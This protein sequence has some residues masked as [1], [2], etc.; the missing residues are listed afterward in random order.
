MAKSIN[1]KTANKFLL[2]SI[3]RAS[4]KNKEEVF[5]KKFKIYRSRMQTNADNFFKTKNQADDFMYTVDTIEKKIKKWLKDDRFD[6][7]ELQRQMNGLIKSSREYQKQVAVIDK[8]REMI[9]Q[10]PDNSRWAYV[11]TH[12]VKTGNHSDE[13]A[14]DLANQPTEGYTKQEMDAILETKPNHKYCTC[15]GRRMRN[16][17]I[18]VQSDNF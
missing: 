14:R 7:K 2:N 13:C 12:A 4:D 6:Q 16:V 15:H 1:F 5:K 17:K 8:E 18:L 9:K 10:A 11:I 3:N